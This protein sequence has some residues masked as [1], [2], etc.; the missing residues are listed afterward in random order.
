MIE[1][2]NG[3]GQLGTEL[4]AQLS[5]STLTSK[6]IVIY[7]TWNF[8]DKSE[9]IQKEELEKFKKFLERTQEKRIIFISTHSEAD[10]NYVHYKWLAE[11]Y[12]LNSHDSGY[13]IRLPNLIGKGICQR[14]RDEKA[15][16]FGNI[17]LLTIEDAAKRVIELSQSEWPER[18]LRVYGYHIPAKIV[19]E[20]ILFGKKA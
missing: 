17:E 1:L 20:L 19:R 15:E 11:N 8:L 9:G 7:H 2:I 5:K 10:N 6:N 13:V 18:V 3:R 16:A 14:F 12:L 4:K